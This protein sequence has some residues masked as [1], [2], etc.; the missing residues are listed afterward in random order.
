ML[1][2]VPLPC[3]HLSNRSHWCCRPSVVSCP[4]HG[5]ARGEVDVTRGEFSSSPPIPWLTVAALPMPRVLTYE[6]DAPDTRHD[7]GGLSPVSS[8]CGGSIRVGRA[9]LHR[10]M[11]ART[12]EPLSHE[13]VAVV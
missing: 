8:A 13:A 3:R 6:A 10:G 11:T 4:P 2:I 9:L 12:F 7:E 5:A 1:D